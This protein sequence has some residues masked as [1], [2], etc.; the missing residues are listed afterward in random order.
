MVLTVALILAC[1]QITLPD[2]NK[3]SV[4]WLLETHAEKNFAILDHGYRGKFTVYYGD[5][6]LVEDRHQP[7]DLMELTHA[8]V[9]ISK[10]GR[11][12]R[13]LV[14]RSSA[15]ID[16]LPHESSG[17]VYVKDLPDFNRL[18]QISDASELFGM[19]GESRDFHDTWMNRNE[20]GEKTGGRSAS[21]RGFTVNDDRCLRIVSLFVITE[22]KGTQEVVVMRS[23]REGKL[24]PTLGPPRFGA[25]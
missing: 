18:C 10:D 14:G 7:R 25:P 1:T 4:Q 12:V 9:F 15:S 21:W 22:I 16:E 17:F 19:F 3:R 24:V 8:W 13:K 6:L 23:L 20:R 5:G 11:T 2:A